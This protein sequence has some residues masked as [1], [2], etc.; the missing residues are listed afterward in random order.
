MPR[1]LHVLPRI[2][3]TESVAQS[4][5][6]T[7]AIGSAYDV[8]SLRLGVD[9]PWR[10]GFDLR[11]WRQL[12]EALQ[13]AKPDVIQ[14]WLS[15]DDW[16]TLRLLTRL[17]RARVIASWREVEPWPIAVL[18]RLVARRVH[19]IVTPTDG[20]AEAF[21]GRGIDRSKLTV[22]P[23]RIADSNREPTSLRLDSSQLIPADA[24]VIVAVGRWRWSDRWRELMWSADLLKFLKLPVHLVMCGYGDDLSRAE[25]YRGQI[26]IADR[27]HLRP[28]AE[29]AAWLDRANCFWSLR[30]DPGVSPWLLAAMQHGAPVVTSRTADHRQIITDGRD[31]FLI[32]L[33]SRADLA[34]RTLQMIEDPAI[35]ARMSVAAR[36][37]IAARRANHVTLDTYRQLYG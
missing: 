36:E 23:D 10:G 6:V 37:T 4:A 19:R 22:V 16:W 15:A 9:L 2:D 20:L 29:A 7:Q 18:P 1:L 12:D 24:Q 3:R 17:S 13:R 27:V 8:Q 32:P 11:G 28:I 14:A 33:G 35:A 5:L 25:K 30:D 26:E 21:A 34:K 31:G